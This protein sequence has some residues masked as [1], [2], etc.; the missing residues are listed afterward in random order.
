MVRSILTAREREILQLVAGG[1]TDRAIAHS[2]A[3]SSKTVNKHV[4]SCMNKL[5][6]QSRAQAVALALRRGLIDGLS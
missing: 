4:A 1:S 2:L 6:A 5:G 3:I